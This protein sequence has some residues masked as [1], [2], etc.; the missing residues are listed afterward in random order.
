MSVSDIKSQLRHQFLQQRKSLSKEDV[1][2]ASHQVIKNIEQF[3][4]KHVKSILFY[5]PINNEVDLLPLAKKFFQDGGTVLFPRLINNRVLPYIIRDLEY[6]FVPGAYNIPEPNTELFSEPID[7]VLVPGIV[8]SR[9]C[10]R[11]G[12]GKGYFDRFLFHTDFKLSIGAAFDFQ[13]VDFI[14]HNHLD[15]Q[16]DKIVTQS[17]IISRK[18]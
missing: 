14:P 7:L 2:N 17:E 13:V 11:I 15:Y 1:E 9:D 6:D 16:L 12:Y 10:Y 4:D 18:D 3:I 5:I 8:F